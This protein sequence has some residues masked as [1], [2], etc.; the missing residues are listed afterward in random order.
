MAELE[1]RL[2]DTLHLAAHWGCFVLLDEGDALVEKR[3]NG[4]QDISSYQSVF[5]NHGGEENKLRINLR[6][7][8]WCMCA[9]VWCCVR[10]VAS[11]HAWLAR[12]LADLCVC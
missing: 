12:A 7:K 5:A 1:E 3:T 4:K 9:V 10:L 8:P 6:C 11:S 2:T